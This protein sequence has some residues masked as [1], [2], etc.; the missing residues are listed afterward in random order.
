M[1][2]KS[3]LA[4]PSSNSIFAG[5]AL[6]ILQGWPANFVDCLVTSPPYWQQR[7][8][9]GVPGQ[10][11]REATPREYTAALTAIFRQ[12]RR[13]LKPSGTLWLVIGLATNTWMVPSSASPGDSPS[14]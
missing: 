4:V 10:V 5:H 11:G 7:D 14:P 13:V 1:D 3:S 6:E 8:Y 2:G 9:R 12:C